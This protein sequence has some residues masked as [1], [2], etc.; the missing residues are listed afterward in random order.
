MLSNQLKKQSLILAGSVMACASIGSA[1]T[2]NLPDIQID[3]L[4]H[5]YFYDMWMGSNAI[6]GVAIPS[7]LG[8]YT[9]TPF[10][11]H[12]ENG[13]TIS[14]RVVAPSGSQFSVTRDPAFNSQMFMFSIYWIANSDAT[15]TSAMPT[16][17]FENLVGSAPV[18]SYTF[19]GVGDV[20]HVIH[21]QLQATVSSDFSF[22]GLAMTYPVN[23]SP[24]AGDQTFTIGSSSSVSF[25]VIGNGD[26]D[27]DATL[28][29]LTAVPEPT[30]LGLLGAIGMI[31]LRRQRLQ[32]R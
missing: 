25:G 28:M 29:S 1:A 11:G 18:I 16:V 7:G 6:D 24:T 26:G 30:S 8:T 4:G 21:A 17:T 23:N 19:T 31:A 9:T 32:K 13:D 3:S 15:S 22:T 14:Q 5:Q 20:G 12:A 27:V 10:F 2:V